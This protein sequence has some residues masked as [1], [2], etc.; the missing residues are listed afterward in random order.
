M[1]ANPAPTSA[2]SF[3]PLRTVNVVCLIRNDLNP[4]TRAFAFESAR[5]FVNNE[6][7]PTLTSGSSAWMPA[8]SA[9]YLRFPTIARTS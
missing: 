3:N 2:P 7:A 6:L 4:D 5:K 8:V 1:G 9:R